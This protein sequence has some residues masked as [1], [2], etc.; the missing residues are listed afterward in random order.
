MQCSIATEFMIP[1]RRFPCGESSSVL[2]SLHSSY[3]IGA[4][5]IR[6][7]VLLFSC[8]LAPLPEDCYVHASGSV[9]DGTITILTKC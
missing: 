9:I 7:S 5:G 2:L 3:L 4:Y 6:D 1:P 8:A